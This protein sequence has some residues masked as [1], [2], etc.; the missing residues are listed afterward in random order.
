MQWKQIW[1][2]SYATRVKTCW[3]SLNLNPDYSPSSFFCMSLIICF[4]KKLLRLHFYFC[5]NIFCFVYGHGYMSSRRFLLLYLFSLIK[6]TKYFFVLLCKAPTI[7]WL[8]NCWTGRR[9][10]PSWRR[11]T[12]HR[13]RRCTWET[14]GAKI[15]WSFWSPIFGKCFLPSLSLSYI[16]SC[17]R[18][19]GLFIIWPCQIGYAV[20]NN[21][22]VKMVNLKIPIQAKINKINANDCFFEQF[23]AYLTKI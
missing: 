17:G 23:Y 8:R 20:V 19:E 18:L 9:R 1:W 7:R 6:L 12:T 13:W 11:R 5:S 14:L 15:S 22:S 16:K 10:C 3:S 4:V 2:A 21:W